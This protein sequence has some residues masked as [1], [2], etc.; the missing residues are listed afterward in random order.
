M[1]EYV[2]PRGLT[3]LVL[4]VTIFRQLSFECDG[5][6]VKDISATGVVARD[7]NGSSRGVRRRMSK[8]NAFLNR[9]GTE[10]SPLYQSRLCVCSKE[11]RQY[12]AAVLATVM[13]SNT[14]YGA[15]SV[16]EFVQYNMRSIRRVTGPINLIDSGRAFQVSGYTAAGLCGVRLKVGVDYFMVLNDPREHSVANPALDKNIFSIN[17]CL[18]IYEYKAVKN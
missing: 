10:I 18:Q 11:K 12:Y 5:V 17:Q 16:V 1:N 13:S 9:N 8:V 4:L 6:S 2:Q 15:G 7:Q 3:I 14:I